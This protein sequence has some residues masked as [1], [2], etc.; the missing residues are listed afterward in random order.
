MKT[1]T[2]RSTHLS[3]H[4]HKDTATMAERAAHIFADQCETAIAERGIFTVA[5]SG[6]VTP[7]PLYKLLSSADW[8]ERLPWDKIAI[9][10]V[11]ECCVEPDNINSFYN[12]TRENLL[13][14]VNATHF[15]RMRGEDHAEK[16][17]EHY[18]KLLRQHFESDLPRFDFVLLGMS[19]NGNTAS[20]FPGSPAL[21]EKKRLC[22]DQYVPDRKADRLTLTL[23]V[24]NNA[25]CCLFLV[26][27]KEK[28]ASL[29]T[30]LNLL[31]PPQLPAQMIRPVSGELIWIVDDKAALGA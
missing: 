19:A 3:L 6:G 2:T 1:L 22:L 25:R 7:L 17:A 20:M 10:W 21:L 13:S 15:Y 9:Y 31:A 29:Q 26:S 5:L 24:I 18:D 11:N 23:P 4:V 14:N 27:G 28:H 16:A 8:A 30:A 12:F